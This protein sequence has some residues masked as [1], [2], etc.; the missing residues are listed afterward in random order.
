[1]GKANPHLA[2][3]IADGARLSVFLE[4]ESEK[5][6]L[7]HP[8][9]RYIESYPLPHI[10]VKD[11]QVWGATRRTH[12]THKPGDRVD[13]VTSFTYTDALPLYCLS[14]Y[15]DEIALLQKRTLLTR[16]LSAKQYRRLELIARPAGPC[17]WR[18]TQPKNLSALDTS[19][20]AGHAHY[21]TFIDPNGTLRSHPLDLA[22]LFPESG[23]VEFRIEHAALPEAF[24]DPIAFETKLSRSIPDLE[25]SLNNPAF[26]GQSTMAAYLTFRCIDGTGSAYGITDIQPNTR[27]TCTD[28]KVYA[29]P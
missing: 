7:A 25:K 17:V 14:S 3:A 24:F 26:G 10:C 12:L 9:P 18:D 1:M 20:Q 29:A 16:L 8:R 5:N 15:N 13:S 21:I 27:H 22:F 4:P 19:I 11:D 2:A 6:T 28:V 23:D